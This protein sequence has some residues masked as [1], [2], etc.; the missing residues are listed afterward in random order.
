MDYLLSRKLVIMHIITNKIYEWSNMW[1]MESNAKKMSYNG[2][3]KE[4]NDTPWNYKLEQNII[5]IEK[6]E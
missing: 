6:E 3:R 4:C 5:S 2:N 1:E